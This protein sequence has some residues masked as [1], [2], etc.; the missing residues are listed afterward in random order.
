MTQP[1]RGDQ[2]ENQPHQI[3]YSDLFVGVEAAR[4]RQVA[5]Y[6]SNVL[7]GM[8]INSS[9]NGGGGIN[10]IYS[11]RDID[12]MN[13][14]AGTDVQDA[15]AFRRVQNGRHN[16]H[17]GLYNG[18]QSQTIA[19]SRHPA[20]YGCPTTAKRRHRTTFTQEQLQLLESMFE[21]NQY[22]DIG[23]REELSKKTALNESRIQVWFQNRRAKFRKQGKQQKIDQPVGPDGTHPSVTLV[24]NIAIQP[25]SLQTASQYN[26]YMN[27]QSMMAMQQNGQNS[28]VNPGYYMPS[29]YPSHQNCFGTN[30]ALNVPTSVPN[31]YFYE[32]P[33][34]QNYESAAHIAAAAAAAAATAQSNHKQSNMANASSSEEYFSNNVPDA[35]QSDVKYNRRN[36]ANAQIDYQYGR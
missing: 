8:D 29:F 19:T 17:T 2:E 26:H 10:N 3:N 23:V 4:Q 20:S 13:Q 30:N 18:V 6:N 24:N 5:A 31:Q 28:M 35:I 25:I 7:Q 14:F 11:H 33:P 32:M 27:F 1:R 9:S 34:Y 12:P 15:G 36:C 22:P 16:D 21:K